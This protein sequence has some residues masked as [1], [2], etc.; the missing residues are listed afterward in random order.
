MLCDTLVEGCCCCQPDTPPSIHNSGPQPHHRY[1]ALLAYRLAASPVLA[2]RLL[3]A[4]VAWYMLTRVVQTAMLACI[5]ADLAQRPQINRQ[6]AFIVTAAMCAALTVL[7]VRQRVGKGVEARGRE[8]KRGNHLSSS[9]TLSQASIHKPLAR[10]TPCVFSPC[11]QAYTLVIYRGID[12]KLGRRLQETKQQRRTD[13]AATPTAANRA[14]NTSVKDTC[15]S[16]PPSSETEQQH[17]KQESL[18]G[19]NAVAVKELGGQEGWGDDG[20]DDE[21]LLVQ[22]EADGVTRIHAARAGVADNEHPGS[23]SSGGQ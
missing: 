16:Q 21:R 3:R 22:L 23:S 5:I 8:G 13:L 18:L 20:D 14:R 4:A 9:N 15:I 11:A 10:E 1:A 17:H 12:R 2:Q 6:P 7:Q 19:G